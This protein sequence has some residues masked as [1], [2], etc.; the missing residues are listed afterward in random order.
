VAAPPAAELAA[1]PGNL[2][3]ESHSPVRP[4]Y[5]LARLKQSIEYADEGDHLERLQAGVRL[6]EWWSSGRRARV[7]LSRLVDGL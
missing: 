7:P 5:R 6:V 2:L 1:D 3:A 4:R